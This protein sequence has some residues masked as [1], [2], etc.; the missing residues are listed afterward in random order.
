MKLNNDILSFVFIGTFF[1]LPIIQLFGA[2]GDIIVPATEYFHVIIWGVPFLAFAMMGNPVIR[3]VGKP[4]YA[5]FT[6]IFPMT[7]SVHPENLV[8]EIFTFRFGDLL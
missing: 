6:M 7:F 5:M 4:N 8:N 1:C 2:N 3:A